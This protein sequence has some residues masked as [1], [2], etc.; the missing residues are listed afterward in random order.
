LYTATVDKWVD[1]LDLAQRWTFKEV[2]Q[3][4]IR[5]LQKLDIEPV[6]KIHIYQAHNINRSHLAESFGK[7]TIRQ[8]FI[9]PEEAQKLGLETTLKISHARELYRSPNGIKPS[10]IQLNDP[11][12]RSAIQDAFG[13]EEESFTDF[14][15]RGFFSFMTVPLMFSVVTSKTGAGQ[16]QPSSQ[17]LPPAI[18]TSG[19]KNKKRSE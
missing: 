8:E 6:D 16:S 11:E 10:P 5:E 1:I 13:L 15:V 3:L 7:L 17:S 14:L 18:D 2:E 4:C 9:N 19:R 12:L